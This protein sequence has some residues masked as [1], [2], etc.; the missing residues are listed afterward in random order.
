MKKTIKIIFMNVIILIAFLVILETGLRLLGRKSI[1]RLEMQESGWAAWAKKR[2]QK[3]CAGQVKVEDSFYTDENGIFRANP[4]YFLTPGQDNPDRI[5]VNAAGFR[6]QAFTDADTDRTK[7]FFI[8]D[9]FTWGASAT[10]LD[11]SFPDLVGKAGYYVYNG[12]IPGVDPLQYAR[13]AEK[14]V[15]LLKPQVTAVCLCLANDLRS[16]ANE[17]K[18]NKNM[19][20]VTDVGWVLGYD[21]QGNYFTNVQ[22]ALDYMK[23]RKC[24]CCDNLW[25]E[26]LYKT[27]IGKTIYDL[28]HR[29]SHIISDP[30]RR[31]VLD[32]L[33]SIRRTCRENGS[34]FM[35]FLILPKALKPDRLQK[36]L[37]LLK[38]YPVFY[39]T[40]LTK[41]D[42]C[43]SP[44]NH[45]NNAGHR[46]FAGF[47]LQV[48]QQRGYSPKRT[49]LT[50]E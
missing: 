30:K 50:V 20:Y 22:E 48:L 40:G 42:Y 41:A 46:K 49:S 14:Y 47:I 3:L 18:A 29:G 10:P 26:F 44:N 43:P 17:L 21:H 5:V 8:G 35:L 6:G 15:P 13:V 27:V 31:W 12:G 32:A 45:F 23:K 28:S 33:N 25:E 19:R 1:F 16:Y 2:C 4:A 37:E 34:E 11:R 39:T 9:S 7:V 38:D 24:G 36:I